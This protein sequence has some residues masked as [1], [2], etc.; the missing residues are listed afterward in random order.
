MG[1]K[2][3]DLRCVPLCRQHHQMLDNCGVATFQDRFKISF[4]DVRLHYLEKYISI[5]EIDTTED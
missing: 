2:P 1:L 3:S 5:R 4:A